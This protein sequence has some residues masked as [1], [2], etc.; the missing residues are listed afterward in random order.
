MSKCVNVNR[1][2][3]ASDYRVVF[4]DPYSFTTFAIGSN[5]VTNTKG[6]HIGMD[7]GFRLSTEYFL[8]DYNAPSGGS[9]DYNTTTGSANTHIRSITGDNVGV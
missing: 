1:T 4:Y 9:A 8:A 5:I 6:R 7:S 3:R 2:Y